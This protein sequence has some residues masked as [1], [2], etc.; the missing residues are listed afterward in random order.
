LMWMKVGAVAFVPGV[1]EHP[2]LRNRPVEG[3]GG[4]GDGPLEVVEPAVGDD[5]QGDAHAGTGSPLARAMS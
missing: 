2:T 5:E 3:G 4:G 1:V